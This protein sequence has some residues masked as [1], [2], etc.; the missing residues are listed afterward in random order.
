MQKLT[1]ERGGILSRPTPGK[2]QIHG[3]EMGKAKKRRTIKKK[4]GARREQKA[5][6]VIGNRKDK[7]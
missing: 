2:R 3:R 1:A 5:S 7:T 6:N 4:K